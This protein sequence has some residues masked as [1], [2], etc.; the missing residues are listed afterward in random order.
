VL[1]ILPELLET[2]YLAEGVTVTRPAT[3]LSKMVQEV[4]NYAKSQPVT[5]PAN[6]IPMLGASPAGVVPMT[7]EKVDIQINAARESG[8]DEYIL[9]AA[10]GIYPPE[11]IAE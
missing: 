9:Y 1:G 3:D 4:L 7:K 6:I 10:N 5:P 11:N 2:G 8:N